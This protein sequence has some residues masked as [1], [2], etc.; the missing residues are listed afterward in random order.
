MSQPALIWLIAGSVLCLIEAV[1]P[2]AFVTFLMGISAIVVAAI[3]L[4]VPIWGLQVFLWLLLSTVLLVVSRR[5]FHPRARH[6]IIGDAQEGETITA[7]TPGKEGRV[8][9]EGNSWRAECEDE[10]IVISPQ[11]K[12]YVVRRRGNTLIVLPDVSKL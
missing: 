10:S 8:L 4:I 2:N 3:A 1:I 6:R 5:W 9:Y 11:E 12:V 7:I